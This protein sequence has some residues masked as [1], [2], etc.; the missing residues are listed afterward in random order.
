MRIL[1]FTLTTN[2]QSAFFIAKRAYYFARPTLYASMLFSFL[3]LINACTQQ[4]PVPPEEI[5]SV[6]SPES[7]GLGSSAILDFINAAEKEQPNALHS[8]MIVR[9]GKTVA[10]GWW[11]PYNPD[12]PHLL[13][14]LSKSFASTAIG[15]AVEEKLLSTDDLVIS[16]FPDIATDT[17]DNNLKAMRIHDLL[18]MNTGHLEDATGRVARGGNDDWVA[19]FLSLPV[20]RKPGTI[21]VYNSAATYMLSAI[22]QKVTGQTM[23]AYLQ[24]RLFDPLDIKPPT[25]ESDPKGINVGGWGLSI[26]TKDIAKFG[27]LYLQK[28]EWDGKQVVPEAWVEK[29]TSYLTSNGSDPENDWE[30]GYGYQFWRCRHNAYRGDGAF[31]QY[32]IVMPDQDAVV[33]ITSGSGDMPGILNLVWT[34]LLP[35]MKEGALPE[36]T[37]AQKALSAKLSALVIAPVKGENTAPLASELTGKTFKFSQNVLG[38]ETVAFSL[39]GE[40]KSVTLRNAAGEQI[41]PVGFQVMESGQFTMPGRPLMKIASSGAWIS[42]ESYRLTMY[43]YESPHA[44]T[45]TFTFKGKGLECQLDENVSFSSAKLPPMKAVLL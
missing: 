41:I 5:L 13:Y 26:T 3:L 38:L 24:P 39:G 1:H 4:A 12:S 35:A 20:E 29:A 37:T 23:V 21:F 30:Q 34:H 31:G 16:F 14:S 43:N 22:L 27:Q 19:A 42:T 33:A 11:N 28:G 15:F 18:R 10:Q 36:D 8:I 9:H 2:R 44:T 45:L 7:Q 17:T 25:W 32:C 40:N 6:S